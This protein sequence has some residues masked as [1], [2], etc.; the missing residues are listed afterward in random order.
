[1]T[2]S[3]LLPTPIRYVIYNSGVEGV[4]TVMRKH[5]DATNKNEA[6][7]EAGVT[8]LRMMVSP[9]LLSSPL[10]LVLSSPPLTSSHL[11]SPS[12]LRSGRGRR[13]G[14]HRRLGR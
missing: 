13:V 12:R 5:V 4:C 9:Q 1:M 2:S 7:A 3:D 11:L 8:A 10:L 6:I 14:H